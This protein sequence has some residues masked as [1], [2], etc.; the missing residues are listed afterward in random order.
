MFAIYAFC[1][2]VDDIADDIK[3]KNKRE[4]L[5]KEWEYSILNIL[6]VKLQ[7]IQL[8]ENYFFLLKNLNLRKKIFYQSYTG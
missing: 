2:I 7:K 8:K 4:K 1:R 6:R 5:L 3:N